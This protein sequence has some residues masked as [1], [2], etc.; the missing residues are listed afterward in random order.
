[1]LTVSK[2][3]KCL[4]TPIIC[5]AEILRLSIGYNPET[6]SVSTT[7]K[8]TARQNPD[9]NPITAILLFIEAL[10]FPWRLLV[11]GICTVHL[12]GKL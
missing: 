12:L 6:A 8:Q 5:Q 9:Q 11:P 7:V 10:P 1:M 2:M 4:V 3:A